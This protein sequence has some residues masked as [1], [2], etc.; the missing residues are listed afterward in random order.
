MKNHLVTTLAA[1]SLMA[2]AAC[3]QKA[4]QTVDNTGNAVQNG[5]AELGNAADNAVDATKMALTATPT[6]QEFADQAAKSDAFEIA[7]AK[8]AATHAA[9]AGVKDFAKMMITAHTES[10]AKVKAAAASASPAITPDAT[11]TD[12]QND[13]LKDLAALNGA[14]FDKKYISGQVDAH[15]EALDLM[16]KY[17]DTGEVASLKTAAGEI[18][19]VVETHLEKAKA[20]NNG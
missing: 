11:L 2:L 7:A 6:G 19:P 10:T 13:A 16:K 1:V 14:D 9:S 3:G 8:L 15:Q 12:D 20:L 5:F 18:A 4:E 17:A